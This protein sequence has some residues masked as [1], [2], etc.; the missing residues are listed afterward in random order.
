VDNFS[1]YHSMKDSGVKANLACLY[2]IKS[3]VDSFAQI[4]MLRSVY[5]LSLMEAKEVMVTCE[6]G[7]VSLDEHQ[8]KLLPSLKKAFEGGL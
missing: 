6:G 5:E 2:A 8:Q 7:S 1:E 4:R 3:G